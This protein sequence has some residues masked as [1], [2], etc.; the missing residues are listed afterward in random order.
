MVEKKGLLP[1]HHGE[2]N[3]DIS[4]D[5]INELRALYANDPLALFTIDQYDITSEV[6]RNQLAYRDA[7]QDENFELAEKIK[8]WLVSQDPRT[9]N[10]VS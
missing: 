2:L 9:S 6:G 4:A 10:N 7:L 5:R 1:E 3:K 8:A